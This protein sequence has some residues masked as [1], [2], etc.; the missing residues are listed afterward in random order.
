MKSLF[1]IALVGSVFFTSL[2]AQDDATVQSRSL[3]SLLGEVLAVAPRLHDLELE[4]DEVDAIT[5]GLLD[6]IETGEI[7]A[8]S[9]DR[10]NLARETM[11]ARFDA[12]NN[13]ASDLP[14]ISESLGQ[15]IGLMT[16]EFS[17]VAGFD[18]SDAEKRDIEYGF[19]IGLEADGPSGEL[20]GRL[21]EVYALLEKKARAHQAVVKASKQE[22]TE[23]FFAG[24][25]DEPGVES[26]ASG[27][28][29][30][31]IEPGVGDPPGFADEVTVHYRGTLIDGRQFDSSYDRGEPATFPMNGVIK[32]FSSGLSKIARGGKVE[33]YIPADLGYG[34]NPRPGGIIEPGDALIFECE[35]VDIS[36]PGDR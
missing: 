18:F 31:V 12:I 19:R 33:I 27:L 5:T 28:H 3:A 8:E 10:F 2:P 25:G 11:Q 34:D 17:G 32:G 36:R 14:P 23:A 26:D 24:L 29:W 20:S 21:T 22:E 15:T 6:S 1:R 16:A 35:L 13:S 4:P 9:R 30:K 7:P